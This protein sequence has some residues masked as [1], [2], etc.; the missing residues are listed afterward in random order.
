MIDEAACELIRSLPYCSDRVDSSLSVGQWY[1]DFLEAC[2]LDGKTR[3]LPK[4]IDPNY[5]IDLGI[6]FGKRK[7]SR[8]KFR[9]II[10]NY[11]LLLYI[12]SIRFRL[13]FL[14]LNFPFDYFSSP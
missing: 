4:F 10:C 3:F 1:Y 6:F 12:M 8:R 14:S 2:L 9:R 5:E 11:F 13:I 7:F